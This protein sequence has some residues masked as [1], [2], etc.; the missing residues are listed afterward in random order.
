M[1]GLV[2]HAKAYELL[3]IEAAIS[4]SGDRRRCKALMTNP[5]VG[6]YD[7]RGSRCSTRCSTPTALTC[8]RFFAAS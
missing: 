1:L 6:D 2:Q 3:T 4:G 5:L 8:R 7:T